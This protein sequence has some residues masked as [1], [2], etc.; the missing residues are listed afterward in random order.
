MRMKALPRSMLPIDVYTADRIKDESIHQFNKQGQK[1]VRV[2]KDN[3]VKA[4]DKIADFKTKRVM[5][6]VEKKK[7]GWAKSEQVGSSVF[8]ENVSRSSV[9]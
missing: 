9:S 7:A 2:K 4:K 3:I 6:A 1:S 8:R 5:K